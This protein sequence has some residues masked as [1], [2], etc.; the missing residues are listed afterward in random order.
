MLL[1][2]FLKKIFYAIFLLF[3]T[4]FSA[5]SSSNFDEL[6][7][8][9][10]SLRIGGNINESIALNKNAIQKFE[11]QKNTIGL[12]SAYI[13]MSD[14]LWYLHKH[15]ESLEYLEK[16]EN[17]LKT[18]KN[19]ELHAKLYGEYGRN[20]SSLGFL[21][22]SNSN[23]NISIYFAKQISDKKKREKLL[24]FYYTWKL[25]NFEEDHLTDSIT[26]IQK[27]LL[28]M[29]PQPLTYVH[30]AEKH[31][32]NK[33]LH[34]TEHYLN[35]AM[36]L[37]GDYNLYQKSMT[38]LTFGKLHSQ[39]KNYDKALEYYLQSLAISKQLSRIKD[40][41]NAYKIIS[42]TYKQINNIEKKNEYL[43]KYSNL[44]DSI[45]KDERKALNIPVK[46]IIKK[47]NQK[48][49]KERTKYYIII[50]IIIAA[51]G[52]ALFLLIKAY[53]KKQKLK[54]EIIDEKLSET[55][56]LKQKLNTTGFD[57]LSKLAMTND[58]F[59]LTRF[60][61]IYPEFYETLTEKYPQLSANDIKFSA[62]L[63]LNLSTKTIAQYK[64][65]SIRTIESRKYR[66]RKKLD[67]PS[68]VDLN[69]WMME[70]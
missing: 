35:K 2:Y 37:T 6:D 29:E 25:E 41:K 26:V 18:V 5:Q 65:I 33:Q 1:S 12:I 19:I 36:L 59:F 67:L 68:D 23:L 46:K 13:N 27:K 55:Q 21:E 42:F 20:Y 70:L 3:A 39:K 57:E 66:L 51:A 40:I 24:Y 44:S 7:H 4:V 38:L 11:Q 10:D 30:I 16:A 8:L 50:T 69:K 17:K 47:E 56:E 14:L 22:Q 53:Q 48:E 61:E 49:Q 62:F 31:L 9:T 64:N 60:K 32:K 45:E 58:P 63:K 52:I 28:E 43:E 54:D 34:S 15:K